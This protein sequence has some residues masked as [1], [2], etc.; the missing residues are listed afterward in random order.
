MASAD[1]MW[2]L[3][4]V[5]HLDGLVVASDSDLVPWAEVLAA[6]PKKALRAEEHPPRAETTRPPSAQAELLAEHPFLKGFLAKQAAASTEAPSE[7]EG[8]KSHEPLAPSTLGDDEL[9]E[10]F[11][12]LEAKRMDAGAVANDH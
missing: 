8:P 3:P 9:Q 1:A 11:D 10:L 7:P 4:N 12:A 2:V 6:L 5:E